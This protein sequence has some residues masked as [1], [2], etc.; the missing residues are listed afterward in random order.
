ML[1]NQDYEAALGPSDGGGDP[2]DNAPTYTKTNDP[3][4]MI[5]R[6]GVKITKDDLDQANK[7]G[8]AWQDLPAFA[9]WLGGWAKKM[10]DFGNVSPY[11]RTY[12]QGKINGGDVALLMSKND[13]QINT[14]LQRNIAKPGE[15]PMFG[16]E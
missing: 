13:P 6:Y 1:G 5:G 15:V 9:D 3:N 16:A 10:P 14:I 8:M 12:P 2:R 11:Y 4:V 7:N